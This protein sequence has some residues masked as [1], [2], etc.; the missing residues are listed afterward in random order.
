MGLFDLFGKKSKVELSEEIEETNEQEDIEVYSGIRVEVTTFDER[1]LFVAKLM[2]VKGNTALMQQYSECGI[3]LKAGSIHVRIRGY[4]A[5]NRKAVYMEG[6]ITPEIKHVWK[7]E[8][9]VVTKVENDRA[10]FRLNVNIDAVIT[11][12]DGP[13][14]AEK[15]CKLLNISIGG[16]Y[17]S[18][19]DKYSEGSRF[20][21]RVRLLA[22]SPESE[23][24]CEVLRIIEKE[25]AWYEYGCRFLDISEEDQQKITQNMFAI[26]SKRQDIC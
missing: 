10:F 5:H 9:L 18:S 1:L 19:E 20:V 21:L 17:I 22:D 23:L 26:Q 25:E 4:G 11:R 6:V 3:S 15:I 16:A 24:L 12:F 13:D 8:G 14:A 2:E 7:V